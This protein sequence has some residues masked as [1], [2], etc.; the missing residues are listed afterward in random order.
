M[1]ALA[2]EAAQLYGPARVL[3]AA[4]CY[5]TAV[6]QRPHRP[7][8][9][10]EQAATQLRRQ[11]T[12]GA[13]DARAVDAVLCAAGHQPRTPGLT[14]REIQVLALLAHGRTNRQIARELG[15]SP[16]TTSNH[17]SPLQVR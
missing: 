13:L 11:A 1:A 10:P 17:M 4:E 3:A 6:E 15:I 5:Q 9:S 8:R 2:A 12:A 14:P 16:K 7:A